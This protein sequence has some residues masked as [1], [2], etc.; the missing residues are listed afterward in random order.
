MNIENF[1]KY[2]LK[3]IEL[4]IKKKKKI[5]VMVTGGKSIT[6]LYHYINTNLSR[7]LYKKI[8]FFITDERLFTHVKNTNSYMVKKN[9]F[10]GINQ[11]NYKIFEFAQKNLNMFENLYNYNS[12]LKD[13]DFLLISYGEDGHIASLFPDLKPLINLKNVSLVYNRSN[14]YKFR[15]SISERMLKKTKNKFLFFIGKNKKKLLSQ[16][17]KNVKKQNYFKFFK[18]SHIII[19]S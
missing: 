16:I 1:Y 7:E 6:K 8:N 4:K 14:K 18:S 19:D 12:K 3:K 17:K 5:N 15:L 11:S 13:I 2:F 10:K 9:L